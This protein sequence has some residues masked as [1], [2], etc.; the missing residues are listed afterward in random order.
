MIQD[1]IYGCT[2]GDVDIILWRDKR[3]VSLISTYHG[4]YFV[5]GNNDQL[6]LALVHDYNLRMGGVDKKDQMLA[7]YPVERKRGDGMQ[8][9][10]VAAFLSMMLI[11]EYRRTTYEEIRGHLG[12]G[13]SQIRKILH[14]HLKVR[15][16]YCRWIPHKLS[17]EH[18]QTQVDW[19]RKMLLKYD[20]RRSDAL[21]NRV[22]GDERWIYYY[23]QEG[24]H[25]SICV[26]KG[27][28][29]PTKLSQAR[30]VDKNLFFFS[31]T[32]SVC[33]ISPEIQK[34]INAE[35]FTSICLYSVLEKVRKKRPKSHIL[36]YHENAYR[37]PR[38]R[39]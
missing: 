17:P 21:Y 10:I 14:Q 2:S 19:C 12:I 16:L 26:F 8:S 4:D 3:R 6:I 18:K 9:S 23:M 27:D 30:S 34:T 33:T 36:L 5:R 13:M 15:K 11:E 39:R 1:G 7:S 25:H 37:T 24:K 29:T 28:S 20:H 38:I 35:W 22:A 32:G 31:K